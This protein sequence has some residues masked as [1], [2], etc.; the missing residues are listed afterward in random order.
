MKHGFTNVLE[1]KEYVENLL[2]IFEQNKFVGMLCP[3]QPINAIGYELC[4]NLDN[5]ENLFKKL[6]LKIPF[7]TN[8]TV[9][10]GAMFWIR[11]D[12]IMPLFRHKWD[13]KDFPQEPILPEGT[14]SHAIERIFPYIVQEAGYISTWVMTEEFAQNQIENLYYKHLLTKPHIYSFKE[15][16]FS[17]KEE[18]N[19]YNLH[20]VYSI[21]GFKIKIK[22]R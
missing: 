7:D 4:G 9:P 2:N 6:N 20:K 5:V 1:S 11:G 13:Y 15:R 16:L 21:L 18:Q 19:L 22:M 8:P 10:F 17:V 12:A 14:I 3:I